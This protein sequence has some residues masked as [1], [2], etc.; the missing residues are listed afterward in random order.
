MHCFASVL[1]GISDIKLIE[2][3]KSWNV[4]TATQG[5]QKLC[6]LLSSPT[7]NNK[8]NALFMVT[9]IS[10]VFNEV[11]VSSGVKYKQKPL[12]LIIDHKK[13]YYLSIIENDIAWTESI[14]T[15][16]KII[17][18]MQKGLLLVVKGVSTSNKK[19]ENS[20]SLLGFKK[21]YKKM[22]Q[23]CNY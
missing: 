3:N 20:Y 16:A 6:Y 21:S 9:Y 10:K 13:T 18:A 11:S 22:Q 14:N 19:I 12:R 15:D 1:Q 7:N 8:S 5:E 17:D 2:K 23:I 4:Y